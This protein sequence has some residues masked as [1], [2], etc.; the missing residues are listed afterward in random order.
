MSFANRFKVCMTF[1]IV[2]FIDS[3]ILPV[4]RTLLSA[5]PD[6]EKRAE[7]VNTY[8]AVGYLCEQVLVG[9]VNTQV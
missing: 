4:M 3:V 7:T 5:E 2:F 8:T 1:I 6:T 9:V